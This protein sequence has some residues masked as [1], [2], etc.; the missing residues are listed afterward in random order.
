MEKRGR[1]A[2]QSVNGISEVLGRSIVNTHGLIH[3]IHSMTQDPVY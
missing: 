2:D 1:E 3:V